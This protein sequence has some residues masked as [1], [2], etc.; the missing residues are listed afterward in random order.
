MV[1]PFL[2]PHT[3]V[4][5]FGPMCV[6]AAAIAGKGEDSPTAATHVYW[7]TGGSLIPEPHFGEMI[8][9]ARAASEP[10]HGGKDH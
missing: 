8:D 5:F 6:A 1:T 3:A 9:A 7:M 10:L 4:A 2:P